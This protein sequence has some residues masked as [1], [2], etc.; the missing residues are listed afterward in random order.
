[1]NTRK[2]KAL[3]ILKG[4]KMSDLASKLGISRSALY[5]KIK[6]TSEFTQSEISNIIYLL[7]ISNPIEI[8]FNTGVS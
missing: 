2:L 7:D 4:V 8:F 1:M 6:G 3:M 5:R